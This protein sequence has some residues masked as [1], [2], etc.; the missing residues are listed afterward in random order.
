M[1]DHYE[2]FGVGPDASKDEIKAAYRAEV[3]NADSARRAELNRAWNVLSDPIQRQRYDESL[4]AFGGGESESS[5]TGAEVVIPS[6]A[7]GARRGAQSAVV[8][9]NG[10]G[11]SNGSGK[12]P[13]DDTPPQMGRNGRPLPTPTVVLPA[14]MH[15]AIKKQRGLSIAFDL[16]VVI[17]LVLG[18]QFLIPRLIDKDFQKNTDIVSHQLEVADKAQDRADRANDRADDAAAAAKKAARADDP[19]AE[20]DAKE[21]QA[22]AK[23]AAKKAEADKKAAEK[24]G[25]DAQ[26]KTQTPLGI[27]SGVAFILALLYTVPMTALTGQSLGKRIRKLWLVR[28]DGT[29]AGWASSF[30]HYVPP[31]AVGIAIPQ[32]GAVVALGMV[33]WSLRDRNEQGLHDKL[34]KTLVVDAPPVPKTGV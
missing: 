28:T 25:D 6:R 14:G 29:K 8:D 17:V 2:L 16:A 13:V 30:A 22:N 3:E 1:T 20:A 31:L 21:K 19:V 4:A 32:I 27:A 33:F 9:T 26:S 7:T 11:S 34:A 12:P 18:S 5:S 10:N 23:A 24:I 15:L